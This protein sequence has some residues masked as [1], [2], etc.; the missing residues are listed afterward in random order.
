MHQAL[1]SFSMLQATQASSG[2]QT[3][4]EYTVENNLL[5]VTT[6][7]FWPKHWSHRELPQPCIYA[8]LVQLGPAPY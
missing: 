7:L 8:G 5:K 3:R 4:L 1:G 6:C 2:L